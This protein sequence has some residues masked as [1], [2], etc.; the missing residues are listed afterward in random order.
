MKRKTSYEFID[1]S[2]ERTYEAYA[3]TPAQAR[4]IISFKYKIP[5]E[6]LRDRRIHTWVKYTEGR[7]YRKKIR[8]MER[9]S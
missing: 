7:P 2:T 6:N 8:K 3:E 9:V 1:T 5:Y 4:R